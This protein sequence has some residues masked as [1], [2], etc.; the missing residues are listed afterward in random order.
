ME[1]LTRL[2]HLLLVK[3]WLKYTIYFPSGVDCMCFF[4]SLIKLEMI[5]M[6]TIEIGNAAMILIVCM[7]FILLSEKINA[8]GSKISNIAQNNFIPKLASSLSLNSL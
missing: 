2:R 8:I 5:K 1:A 4:A 7:F 6:I 3:E